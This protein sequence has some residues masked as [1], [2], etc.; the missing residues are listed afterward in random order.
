MCGIVALVGSGTRIS[1]LEEMVA[2][3]G[4]RGPDGRGQT[5]LGP[6]RLG[7]TRLSVID[8]HGGAQ[9]MSTSDG[10]YTIVF[11]GEIYNFRELRRELESRGH[12]FQTHSDT[13]VLLLA[14][15]EFGE[16]TPGRLVGQFAFAIWD[17]REQSL[18]AARDRFGEKPLYFAESPGGDFIIA[19][20]IR[21]LSAAGCIRPEIDPFA[22]ELYRALLYVPP[23]R[24]IYRNVHTLRPAHAMTWRE[25]NQRA[26][27]YWQ[28]AYSS[29]SISRG[30]AVARVREL[31]DQAVRRQMVADVPVGAFLS[32][33]LDSSTIVALMTRE[34]ERPIMTFSVGFGDQIDEL[35]F[36]RAVAARYG[37]DHHELQMEIPVGEMLERMALVYDEPFADSSNIPTY[38]LSEFARRSVKVVL[39]GDGGDELFGGYDWYK[40]QTGQL[41]SL[42]DLFIGLRHGDAWRRHLATI[43]VSGERVIE[44]LQDVYEPERTQAELDR[45]T[46]FDLRCYL[47]GDILVKVDRAAMAH[48]LETRAPF[49]DPD[50]ADF[51]LSLTTEERFTGVLK[52]LLREACSELWPD[53]VRQRT[54]QG[55]GA[56]IWAWLQRDDVQ[57]LWRRVTAPASPLRS[58]LAQS[59]QGST[60][61]QQWTDLCLGLWLERHA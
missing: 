36:A 2:S 59:G 57:A 24:T 31:L 53:A 34:A 49:L 54:K 50:L 18:F 22:V 11:N 21:A 47:P 25:G 48:G 33:G 12:V 23:H 32:G 38:L 10:R 39:S 37:T 30:E 42:Y 13:E 9:P 8:I 58:W 60:P 6:C 28:P 7:H 3:L 4:H 19:S 55:F 46:D 27:R 51:V 29:H 5:A 17:A 35:P 61:Q 45:V 52:S 40:P 14:F 1:A 20:E 44:E 26:W 43:G 56:P 41:R 15:R 16:A